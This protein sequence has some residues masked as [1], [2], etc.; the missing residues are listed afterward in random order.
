MYGNLV[1]IQGM[2]LLV[3]EVHKQEP[4]CKWLLFTQASLCSSP[5][6]ACELTLLASRFIHPSYHWIHAD[7]TTAMEVTVIL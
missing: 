5:F 2:T 7:C 4:K 6:L 3:D 1:H